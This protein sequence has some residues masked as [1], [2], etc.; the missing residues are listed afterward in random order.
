MYAKVGQRHAILLLRGVSADPSWFGRRDEQIIMAAPHRW[1]ENKMTLPGRNMYVCSKVPPAC[2]TAVFFFL[3]R[4][5]YRLDIES[6]GIAASRSRVAVLLVVGY[7]VVT[8][9]R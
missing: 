1:G 2:L 5:H 9:D 4:Y 6:T 8:S 3:L 7:R